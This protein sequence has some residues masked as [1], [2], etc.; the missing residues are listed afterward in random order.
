M[1]K[2]TKVLAVACHDVTTYT[3][4]TVKKQRKTTIMVPE[5][6]TR[7]LQKPV[8]KFKTVKAIRY[9]MEVVKETQ[10]KKETKMVKKTVMKNVRHAIQVPIQ[11]EARRDCCG[12]QEPLNVN[13]APK[14]DGS[15]ACEPI[16]KFETKWITKFMPT[17]I[18]V[19]EVVEVPCEVEVQKKVP[20]EVDVNEPVVS[21]ETVTEDYT[22]N[23]PKEKVIDFTITERIPVV[24]RLCKDAHGEVVKQDEINKIPLHAS[25]PTA[26]QLNLGNQKLLE[27]AA[28][29]NKL[30]E[31]PADRPDDEEGDPQKEVDEF[32]MRVN[33][34]AQLVL[35]P[36][37]GESKVGLIQVG[38]VT[39]QGNWTVGEHARPVLKN[40][41]NPNQCAQPAGGCGPCP[42]GWQFIPSGQQVTGVNFQQNG[43]ANV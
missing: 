27:E 38:G 13:M 5:T 9:K 15:C 6:R 16:M 8:T 21:F 23:V 36:L 18:E 42:A 41:C 32:K 22:V 14:A 25:G 30:P 29:E 19:P 3:T 43:M 26:A 31:G 33:R 1:P 4:R 11:P 17:T 28:R 35:A 20:Y 10:M 37:D 2:P 40:S 24:T 7:T 34:E 39:P 12:R